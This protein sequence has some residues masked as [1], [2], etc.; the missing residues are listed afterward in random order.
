MQPSAFVSTS[1]VPSEGSAGGA[2]RGFKGRTCGVSR[3]TKFQRVGEKGKKA[4]GKGTKSTYYLQLTAFSLLSSA[5]SSAYCL[6]LTLQLTAF[7]LP[8]S[9]FSSSAF[10]SVLV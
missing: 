4:A 8:S 5:Y 6:Q 7:S 9:A 10:H 2:A 3:P 1:G